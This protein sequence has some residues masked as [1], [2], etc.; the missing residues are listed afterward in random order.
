[1]LHTKRV[2]L[3]IFTYCFL[4]GNGRYG[5]LF[6]FEEGVRIAH[7][8]LSPLDGQNQLRI[9]HDLSDESRV[10][11]H[12]PPT[13]IL[14][15]LNL[16]NMRAQRNRKVPVL[17]LNTILQHLP[18]FALIS[19]YKLISSV[20]SPLLYKRQIR[21]N[22]FVSLYIYVA[23]FAAVASDFLRFWL[24]F[25]RSSILNVVFPFCFILRSF[26]LMSPMPPL[27]PSM[28]TRMW[29]ANRRSWLVY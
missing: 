24:F 1:M 7:T 13:F 11:C 8:P 16:I 3:Y 5:A 4:L 29:S 10:L 23:S 25:F 18:I 12:L 26:V 6:I 14:L 21:R 17:P 19:L 15:H 28:F 20:N 2:K 22:L 27:P 9:F